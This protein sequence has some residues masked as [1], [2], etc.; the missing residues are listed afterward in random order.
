VSQLV[1]I[2]QEASVQF[3]LNQL[4]SLRNTTHDFINITV[5]YKQLPIYINGVKVIIIARLQM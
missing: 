3:S 5:I 4:V 2:A 1:S